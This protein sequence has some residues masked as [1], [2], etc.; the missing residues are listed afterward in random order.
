M[1]PSNNEHCKGNFYKPKYINIYI[2]LLYQDDIRPNFCSIVCSL[3]FDCQIVVPY[4]Y[5]YIYVYISN[6]ILSLFNIVFQHFY[7]LLLF[8]NYKHL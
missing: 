4:I 1:A 7:D 8:S 5:I 6:R 2:Y 3:L